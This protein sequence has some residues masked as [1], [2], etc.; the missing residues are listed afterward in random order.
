MAQMA[1]GKPQGV[2]NDRPEAPKSLSPPP[3]E[4]PKTL[5]K[6][7]L[8][9]AQSRADIAAE[10]KAQGEV[11]NEPPQAPKSLSPASPEEAP[12]M[13]SDSN[14]TADTSNFDGIKLCLPNKLWTFLASLVV[15]LFSF[16]GLLFFGFAEVGFPNGDSN[17][18]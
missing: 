3:P 1:E 18:G 15:G 8:D 5:S 4:A 16:L 17:L 12:K 6:D 7:S 11:S 14:Q 10:G 2:S 13:L 9:S